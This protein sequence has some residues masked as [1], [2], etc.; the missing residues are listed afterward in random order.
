VGKKVFAFNI[1]KRQTAEK[2]MGAI[3]DGMFATSVALLYY[4]VMCVQEKQTP[5]VPFILVQSFLVADMFMV[6]TTVTLRLHHLATIALISYGF[7]YDMEEPLRSTL[8][9]LEVSSLVLMSMT[10]VPACLKQA[11]ELVFYGLYIKTRLVDL[12]PLLKGVETC[13]D[14]GVWI[15]YLL[16][17]YWFAIISRKG[18]KP[19]I[20]HIVVEDADFFYNLVLVHHASFL[21][22]IVLSTDQ[23]FVSF[24]LHGFV[25]TTSARTKTFSFSLVPI[26]YDTLQ[27]TTVSV[28]VVVLVAAILVSQQVKPFYQ[29]TF[30]FDNFLLGSL[31]YC[32]F[33]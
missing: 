23:M 12:Y 24:L 33:S 16:S 26:L 13:V 6:S 32:R 7:V 27:Y 17:V 28:P 14:A 4:G 29:L 5:V 22:N 18:F 11:V 21:T 25:F 20:A 3:R 2:K 1:N 9:N 19:F 31:F 10:Y 30:L 8:M 15:L